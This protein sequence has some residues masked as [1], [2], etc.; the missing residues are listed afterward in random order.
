MRVIIVF[1]EDIHAVDVTPSSQVLK[2][3]KLDEYLLQKIT[4]PFTTHSDWR[5][6]L[7]VVYFHYSRA[8]NM[9]L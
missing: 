8:M 1:D 6:L 7:K 2:P 5:A 4:T 3:T 9:L